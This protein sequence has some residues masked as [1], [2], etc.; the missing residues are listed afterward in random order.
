MCVS[1]TSASLEGCSVFC[2][3]MNLD[4][5]QDEWRLGN[6]KSLKILTS[7]LL[8]SLISDGSVELELLIL[9]CIERYLQREKEEK[10][11][12]LD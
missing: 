8:L 5:G 9:H 3:M 1:V 11:M 6:V 12:S 7:L 4:Q 2:E 10:Q